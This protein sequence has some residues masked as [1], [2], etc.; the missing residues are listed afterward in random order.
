MIAT[1]SF[2]IPSPNTIEKSFGYL[3]GFIIVNAATESD[4]Q[5]VALYLT[6]NAVLSLIYILISFKSLI[7][8]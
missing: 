1:A 6:I 3:L 8:P 7:N 4:A 2:I 5:I